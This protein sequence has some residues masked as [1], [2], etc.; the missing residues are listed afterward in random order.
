MWL[1][2]MLRDVFPAPRHEAKC[3]A[4]MR[5]VRDPYRSGQ[6]HPSNKIN[7]QQSDEP[8]LSTP[9]QYFPV[10][11]TNKKNANTN[12]NIQKR[13]I[14]GKLMLVLLRLEKGPRG[15]RPR[16]PLFEGPKGHGPRRCGEVI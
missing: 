1:S 14:S 2:G 16:P 9:K 4:S 11:T 7:N 10:Q 12:K 5:Q 8:P 13:C 6:P 15:G 3:H